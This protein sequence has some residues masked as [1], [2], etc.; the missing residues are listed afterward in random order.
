M[1]PG[2]ARVQRRVR[3]PAGKGGPEVPAVSRG[4][5]IAI[6][7]TA[8][9]LGLSAAV[10]LGWSWQQRSRTASSD[11]KDPR[12]EQQ[13]HGPD[14]ADTDPSGEPPAPE[15]ARSPPPAAHPWTRVGA[16]LER[17]GLARRISCPIPEDV[18]SV[19]PVLGPPGLRPPVHEG[20]I[21]LILPPDVTSTIALDDDARPALQL[22][23]REDGSGCTATRLEI[24]RVEGWLVDDEGQPLT[25]AA[26]VCGQRV[27]VDDE[28]HFELDDPRPTRLE[29]DGT[30]GV[31]SCDVTIPGHRTGDST[32]RLRDT[33]V[34]LVALPDAD[35]PLFT[36]EQEGG[37]THGPD[38]EDL[39]DAMLQEATGPEADW[40]RDH[41]RQWLADVREP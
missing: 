12:S 31:A 16:L 14:E 38:E 18:G 32:F 2:S 11:R 1:S 26:W 9:L 3:G 28:G 27:D 34:E 15:P 30:E 8:A 39:V 10:W 17:E 25:E 40:L 41:G 6:L 24:P 36:D 13:P 21:E 29:R 4:R 33:V 22:S 37:G 20:R 35:A 7:T 19:W 5:R 23:W